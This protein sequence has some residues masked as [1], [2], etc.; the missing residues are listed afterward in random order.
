[1]QIQ[2]SIIARNL[3]DIAKKINDK[4]NMN[5][6]ELN[7]LPKNMSAIAEAMTTFM[8]ILGFVKESLR[9]VLF[10]GEFDEY[11]NEKCMHCTARLV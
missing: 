6:G 3:P 5:L 4:L 2:A 7:K 11:P 10:R 9:K 8:S 1:M